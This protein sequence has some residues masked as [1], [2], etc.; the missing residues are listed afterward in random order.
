MSKK[1]VVRGGQKILGSLDPGT[2]DPILTKDATTKDIGQ[3]PAIDTSTFIST[4]LQSGYLLVGN[5]LNV[6]IPRQITGGISIN[7]IGVASISTDYITNAHIN[8]AAGISYSKLNLSNSIVNSDIAAAANIT[9]TKIANGTAYRVLVNNGAG[10]FSENA[11]ISINRVLISDVN[12]LPIHSSVTSTTLTYLDITSSLQGLLDDKLQF[13]SSITPAEGDIIQYTGG[14]WN[15]VAIGSEG[16]VLTVVSG[17]PEWASGVSNGLPVG[18]TAGQYLN[19]IDGT[20]YNAQWSTLVLAKITDITATAAEVNILD[21]ATLSTTELNYV[22]GVTSPIQAQIDTKLDNSLAH[23]AIFVGNISNQAA[24]LA[25]GVNGY[26][27]TMVAGSPQWQPGVGGGH[28]IQDEGTP[29][30]QRQ[31]LNFVGAGVTVTDDSGN[32]ATVVTISSSGGGHIIQ[33]SGLDLPPEPNLNFTN[34]L[35]AVDDI[36]TTAS[37][38]TL[39]GTLIT[40]TTIAAATFNFNILD[41][42][43]ITLET[44]GGDSL[45]LLDGAGLQVTLVGTNTFKEAADY[46]ANYVARSYISKG[47]SDSGVQTLT[48]KTLSTGTKIL[49]GSDA[50]GD[51]YYNGGSGTTARLAD[52]ATGNVLLSGGVG[53]APLY[54]KVTSSHVDSTIQPSGLAWLLASG[55]TLTGNNTIVTAGFNVSFTGTGKVLFNG[56]ATSAPVNFA[57]LAADPSSNAN[58]DVWYRNGGGVTAFRVYSGST[59]YNIPLVGAVA[60]NRIAY[61]VNSVGELQSSG[62]LIFDGTGLLVG[63]GTITANT[64]VDIRGIGTTT[65]LILRLADSANTLRWSQNDA[66]FISQTQQGVGSTVF[67]NPGNNLSNPGYVFDVTANDPMQVL[68][69]RNTNAG[70]A[71]QAIAAW[72]NNVAEVGRVYVT[73]G[74]SGTSIMGV[75]T[76]VASALHF[77]TS[78][79]SRFRIDASGHFRTNFT[80][81]AYQSGIFAQSNKSITIGSD[82][83]TAALSLNADRNGAIQIWHPNSSETSIVEEPIAVINT[84]S[85]YAAG[86]GTTAINIGGAP[87]GTEWNAATTIRF[88]T[89]SNHNTLIG[90]ERVAIDGSGLVLIGGGTVTA[91]TRLDVR[92]TGTTTNNIIRAANSSNSERFSIRDNGQTFFTSGSGDDFNFSATATA[93]AATQRTILISGG[94]TGRGT[95]ADSYITVS[96]TH[97]FT[98]GATNQTYT[99]WS[100]TATYTYNHTGGILV[101]YDWNPTVAGTQAAGVTHYAFRSFKGLWQIGD[102]S[103][104]TTLTQTTRTLTFGGMSSWGTGSQFTYSHGSSSQATGIINAFQIVGGTFNP[105]AGTPAFTTLSLNTTFA[106]TNTASTYVGVNLISTINQTASSTGDVTGFYFNPTIT[107]SLG[108]LYAFRSTSGIVSFTG[109]TKRQPHVIYNAGQGTTDSQDIDM[110]LIIGSTTTVNQIVLRAGDGTAANRIFVTNATTGGGKL[111]FYVGESIT[112]TMLSMNA[113]GVGVNVD[114]I[115][116]A[117]NT[118]F[119][120]RGKGTTTNFALRVADSA[121]SVRYTLTDAGTAI[122]VGVQ[123]FAAT[124][125]DTI[126]SNTRLDVRGVSGGQAF[127]VARFDNSAGLFGISDTGITTLQNSSLTFSAGSNQ[128]FSHSIAATISGTSTIVDGHFIGGTA[129]GSTG[130]GLTLNMLRIAPTYNFT[131][132][133]ATSNVYGV[134]YDPTLTSMTG[135]THYAWRS[136]SGAFSWTHNV[137]SVNTI[138]GTWTATANNQYHADFTGTFTGRNSAN[139]F[140]YAYKFTPSMTAGISSNRAYAVFINPSFPSGAY[141]DKKAIYSKGQNFFGESDNQLDATIGIAGVGTSTHLAIYVVDSGGSTVWQLQDNGKMNFQNRAQLSNFT[142][143]WTT[144]AADDYH[145]TLNGSINT[146]STSGRTTYGLTRNRAVTTGATNQLF[147]EDAILT[148]YTVNHTGVTLIGY[149]YN[150]AA[151]AGS[152]T[153]TEIAFRAVRGQIVLGTT[154]PVANNRLAVRGMSTG[155]NN[156]LLLEDSGGTD[157]FAFQDNGFAFFLTTPNNDNALTQVLV[158]DSGTGEIKYRTAA[159]L[160]GGGGS[161]AGS[162]DE[163]QTSDGAGGFVASKLFFSETT[164]AMT[165]GDSGLAGTSRSITAV[166]SGGNV[167]IDIIAKSS[168][169]KVGAVQGFKVY[170][171]NALT[172]IIAT[173]EKASSEYYLNF[174]SANGHIT[175]VQ[176]GGGASVGYSVQLSGSYASGG[177]GTGISGDAIVQSGNATSGDTNT[178]YVF[179]SPGTPTGTGTKGNISLNALSVSSWQSMQGGIFVGNVTAAPSGNPTSGSYLWIDG[180]DD[181]KMKSRSTTG[182]IRT[183]WSQEELEN[184]IDSRLS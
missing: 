114:T 7:N 46:S 90:T 104:N 9:R 137:P 93:V 26:V 144:S 123:L 139:D 72:V 57:S 53:T 138:T 156:T 1:F 118:S 15:R 12:G 63:G 3:I 176:T 173:I 145:I 52:V 91:G 60:T 103:D 78:N 129:Q 146:G 177:L 81:A 69:I 37:V 180:S 44:S 164:G 68:W 66:G 99:G 174:G 167:S 171:D 133:V 168:T 182:V 67:S 24:Q 170:A 111:S 100:N 35:T 116:F 42:N 71:A 55:G 64:R 92:G 113:N 159:S 132:T 120:I 28:V 59:I 5:N 141:G 107:A 87:S 147:I 79:T 47:Y 96:N 157:R 23:N 130:S 161:S 38:V 77:L 50:T 88:Y 95:S 119:D 128:L 158:R 121:N 85:L 20:N 131:G 83:G 86:T 125:S 181:N 172:E 56:T 33:D 58:G 14:A 152:Q 19:K 136:T 2:G 105:S 143:T 82:V 98:S 140:F 17:N 184:L 108:F 101:G 89:A 31:Y 102:G 27:L 75:G 49:L 148:T 115:N 25:A 97:A 178:G 4:T 134:N 112:T 165:L 32:D 54:G 73:S 151:L 29:L 84:Q 22:D 142:G 109:N 13:D 76:S 106:P 51:I 122:L 80:P 62:N 45:F 41:L 179:I 40:D 163:V 183:M 94:L 110:G 117:A 6:A 43:S 21:G 126:T 39:G 149:D 16:E 34:G 10:V 160:G 65:N 36:G 166:G 135:I 11:P 74:A 30:T 18:G 154:T 155:A 48:N 61:Y 70:G 124:S 127:R 175:A 169:V 162:N 150:P 153:P 8:S